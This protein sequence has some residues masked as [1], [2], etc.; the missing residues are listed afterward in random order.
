MN[1]LKKK[2][3]ETRPIFTPMNKL[4]MYSSKKN[5]KN[6]EFISNVGI[7]LPSYPSL[8]NSEISYICHQ[9]IKFFKRNES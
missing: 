3:I 6:S 2:S 8:K 4:K 1:F 9:I 5:F 7:S